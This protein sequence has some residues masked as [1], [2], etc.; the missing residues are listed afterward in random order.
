VWGF[1]SGLSMTLGRTLLH[2]QVPHDLR[3]RA[4]SVYQLCLFGG[5][6][7]GAWGCGFSIEAIG[8]SYTFISIAG[9]TLIVSV[10]AF[11]S[12]LWTLRG[13]QHHTSDLVGGKSN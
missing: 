2:N 9:L 8:L 13:V 3:S 11:F 7:L 10:V 1:F 12:P 5:A 6:P 4:S